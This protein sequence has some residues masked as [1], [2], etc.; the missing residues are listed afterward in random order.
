LS[1][2]AT[3]EQKVTSFSD[4]IRALEWDQDRCDNTIVALYI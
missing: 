3:E 2:R 4:S 1:I